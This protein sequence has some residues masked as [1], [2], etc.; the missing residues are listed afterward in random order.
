MTDLLTRT[1]QLADPGAA[2]DPGLLDALSRTADVA[3][4]REAGRLLARADP[5]LVLPQG[6]QPRR[7]RVAVAASFTADNLVPLLNVSLLVSGI[8]AEIHL[9]PPDQLLMQ[10]HGRDSGLARFAPDLTLC[11]VHEQFFLPSRDQVGDLAG[12]QRHADERLALFDAAVS[13]FAGQ[14][15]GAVLLHTVPLPQDWLKTVIAH[16]SRARWGR[17]WRTLNLAVLELGERPGPVD[18]LDLEALLTGSGVQLRDERLNRFAG[19]AWSPAAEWLFAREAAGYARAL[20]GRSRKCLVL[21][22]DNTLWGGVLGDDGPA[23]IDIGPLY[24]GNAYAELQRT[25]L[26]LRR[27][28]VLLAVASK[29]DQGLVQQVF[30]EHPEFVLRAGDFVAIKANW[31][32]KDGTIEQLAAELNLGLDSF[33]FADDS[34][35]ECGLVRRSL[36]GVAVVELAGDPA[37]HVATLLAGGHFDV[38]TTTETDQERTELYRAGTRRQA[39]RRS[40][41]STADYLAELGLEV[42]LRPADEYLLPRIVQLGGRTNQFNL[43]GSAHPEQRTREMAASASHAVLGFEAADRFG[44]EGLVGALWIAKHPDHWLIENAVLSCRVFARGIEFAVLQAVADQAVAAGVSRLEADFRDSGRN[45][46]GDHFL[47]EAGFTGPAPGSATVTR[48]L[49]L[50]PRPQLAPAWI[51]LRTEERRIASHA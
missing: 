28:G 44:R 29:N 46:P 36:P 35:F 19:M 30:A 45:G 10:L 32:A 11:L 42:T 17:L 1:R 21:D 6:R 20:T 16:R 49:A 43:I 47:R 41:S 25:A 34:A 15:T 14:T 24:P 38:L 22:L 8:D 23:N 50:E 51:V 2:P 5:A 7:L 37:G 40:R 3:V 18:V 33:V 26:A 31:A 12:V 48:R 9:I 4:A 27:Q 13:A 39:W